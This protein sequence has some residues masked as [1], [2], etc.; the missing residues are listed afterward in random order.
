MGLSP[1]RIPARGPSIGPIGV[2]T[3]RWASQA[4][5]DDPDISR[6]HTG[7]PRSP[8]PPQSLPS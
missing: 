2:A 5:P 1:E 4:N 6:S 7:P 3:D 8:P